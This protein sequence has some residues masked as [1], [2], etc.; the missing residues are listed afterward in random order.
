MLPTPFRSRSCERAALRRWG[1]RPRLSIYNIVGGIVQLFGPTVLS[2]Q[3]VSWICA[4]ACAVG[5]CHKI[6]VYR[7]LSAAQI[8]FFTLSSGPSSGCSLVLSRDC[9]GAVARVQVTAPFNPTVANPAMSGAPEQR[10]SGKLM[11]NSRYAGQAAQAP[12]RGSTSPGCRRATASDN[13]VSG[14]PCAVR[15]SGPDSDCFRP[16]R[17]HLHGLQPY[18]R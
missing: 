17:L 14:A 2:I 10:D 18:L 11:L 16:H 7:R 8:D 4:L 13:P 6:G 3:L 5:R 12:S 9:Q 15:R 1:I